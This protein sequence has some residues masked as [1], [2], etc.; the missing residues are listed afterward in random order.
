M[1]AN[2]GSFDWVGGINVNFNKFLHGFASDQLVL[3]SDAKPFDDHGLFQ[4]DFLERGDITLSG[5]G[6]LSFD[7]ADTEIG[8]KFD[9]KMICRCDGLEGVKGCA[10][11][12]DVVSR[13]AVDH[14][15]GEQLSGLPRVLA[16]GDR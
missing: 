8:R 5:H 14:K 15:K 12:D 2:F 9:G 10:A 4:L 3:S 6:L 16:N 1:A 13:G 7:S 11:K